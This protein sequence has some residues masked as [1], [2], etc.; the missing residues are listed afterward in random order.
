MAENAD[1]FEVLCVCGAKME[2]TGAEVVAKFTSEQ[3][4]E[5]NVTPDDVQLKGLI[6]LNS[7]LL[8]GPYGTWKCK[9]CGKTEGGYS[10]LGR[11]M[12]SVE[13]IT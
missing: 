7:V 4:R 9:V 12:I 10:V 1:N 2:R 3:L 6:E 13:P 8:T 5:L 11:C